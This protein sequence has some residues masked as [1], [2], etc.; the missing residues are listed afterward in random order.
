MADSGHPSKTVPLPAWDA[1]AEGKEATGS[2]GAMSR[3]LPKAT[4][5]QV[6]KGAKW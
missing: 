1:A 5:P 2:I 6:S 4:N 3:D